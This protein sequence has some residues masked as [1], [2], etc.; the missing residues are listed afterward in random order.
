MC[1]RGCYTTQIACIVILILPVIIIVIIFFL[2][3]VLEGLREDKSR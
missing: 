3:Q 1:T 2:Y